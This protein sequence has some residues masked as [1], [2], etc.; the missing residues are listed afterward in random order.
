MELHVWHG[1]KLKFS[2]TKALDNPKTLGCCGSMIYEDLLALLQCLL[3]WQRLVIIL[4]VL[5]HLSSSN[6][7][8][9]HTRKIKYFKIDYILKPVGNMQK[10]R[11][12]CLS[13]NFLQDT[14]HF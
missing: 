13:Q 11:Q 4:T 6:A 8:I 9:V 2:D 10:G 5:N 1:Q 3:V 12:N 14:K 7:L